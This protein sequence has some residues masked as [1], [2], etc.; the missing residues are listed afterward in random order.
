MTRLLLIRHGE[1]DWNR[2]RR[3]QG[4][5]DI[6]LNDTGRRQAAQ[7]AQLL[8]TILPAD[9]PA[10]VVASD[11]LR[12]QETA[13]IIAREL[14][15]DEPVLSP[16]LRERAYGE[17]EGLDVAE[18]TARFGG[19]TTE[20]P[21]AESPAALRVRAIE[22]LRQAIAG[23]RRRTGTAQAALIAVAHGALIRE[24]VAH[25]SGGDFPAPGQ[26]LS[27]GSVHEFLVERDRMRLLSFSAA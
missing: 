17:G 11:L 3:I 15:L 16:L 22:G 10:T 9:V 18:F 2:D 5:T 14:G 24:V 25:A 23:S 27:N 8:R 6:P 1:T 13:A 20:V 19:H 12:A 21:G 26:R 4:V 7:T